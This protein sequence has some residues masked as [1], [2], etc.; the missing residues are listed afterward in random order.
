MRVTNEIPL[1]CSFLLLPVGTVILL[2][3]SKHYRYGVAGVCWR[4]PNI[5]EGPVSKTIVQGWISFYNT[6]REVLTSELLIHV[7]RPD[8]QGLDAVLHADPT[9]TAGA[10]AGGVRGLFF[11][12]NP[13]S[14]IIVTNMSVP[15]YYTGLES[16]AT[17]RSS[18]F[19]GRF[20][21]SR[22]LLDPT[23]AFRGVKLLPCCFA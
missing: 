19:G 18:Y 5:F 2:F 3:P 20:C 7:R 13:T 22:V 10:G 23:P 15:L 12:F 4:G 1:W 6:Y 9:A 8:G 16:I 17:V 11:V 14:D 21:C